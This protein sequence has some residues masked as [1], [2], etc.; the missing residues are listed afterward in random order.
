MI[1]SDIKIAIA[2]FGNPDDVE[3]KEMT[4]AT[5]EKGIHWYYFDETAD[6]DFEI[7]Q[8]CEHYNIVFKCYKSKYMEK[9]K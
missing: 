7:E 4:Q 9:V 6:E 2:Q 1:N 3:L 5:S 8:L